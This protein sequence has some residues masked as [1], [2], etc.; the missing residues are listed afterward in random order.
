MSV[1]CKKNKK[2]F[3]ENEEFGVINFGKE[4]KNKKLKQ[5]QNKNVSTRLLWNVSERTSM[6][7]F[8]LIQIYK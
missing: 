1:K 4:K 6:P 5:K 3:I 8:K 7:W 2:T